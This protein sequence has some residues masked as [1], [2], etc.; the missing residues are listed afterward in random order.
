MYLLFTQ[1]GRDSIKRSRL[2]E[3]EQQHYSMT[4]RLEEMNLVSVPETAPER[5]ALMQDISVVTRCMFRYQEMLTADPS[6]TECEPDAMPD[7]AFVAGVE[8]V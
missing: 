6:V 8:E 5:R 3:L 7:N 1:D 2:Y 4:L